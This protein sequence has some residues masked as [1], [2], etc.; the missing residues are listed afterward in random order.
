MVWPLSSSA[1][2]GN[3][4]R[5]TTRS[6]DAEVIARELGKP[7]PPPA[8]K[9]RPA[10]PRGGTFLLPRRRQ[11]APTARVSE[12]EAEPR[13]LPGRIAVSTYARRSGRIRLGLSLRAGA[14]LADSWTW[15]IVGR[16]VVRII[17]ITCTAW[18]CS[19]SCRTGPPL[20]VWRTS[21]PRSACRNPARRARAN[22]RHDAVFRLQDQRCHDRRR[23]P[24]PPVPRWPR[25]AHLGRSG[26]GFPETENA[27]LDT[28]PPP[29]RR[30]MGPATSR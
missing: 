17:V 14:S 30:T 13:R 3:V 19:G 24:P 10:Y 11:A 23:E 28:T 5:G 4:L 8:N 15:F 20:R 2:P 7:S 12:R 18:R 9:R 25:L 6:G 22:M 1:S 16:V 21:V 26:C 29:H 27:V